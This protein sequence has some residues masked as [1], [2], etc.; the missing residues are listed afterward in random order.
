MKSF[1]LALA[2]AAFALFAIPQSARAQHVAFGFASPSFAFSVG[3]PVVGVPVFGAPVFAQPV[4][5]AQAFGFSRAVA[6]ANPNLVVVR[7]RGFLFNR[8]VVVGGNRAVVVNGNRAVVVNNR[9]N[10]AFVLVR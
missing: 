6:V 3:Q 8:A 7:N 10:R 1:C 9:A 5:G 4:F 2:F